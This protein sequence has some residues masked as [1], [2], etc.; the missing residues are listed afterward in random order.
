MKDKIFKK[1]K[2]IIH[3]DAQSDVFYIG[4]DKKIEEEFIEIA[5]GVNIELD[6]KGEVI[7]IEILNASRVLTPV[8]KAIEKKKTIQY[9]FT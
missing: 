6:E 8:S 5:P 7:G 9:A 2:K 3:Y 1:S 4:I